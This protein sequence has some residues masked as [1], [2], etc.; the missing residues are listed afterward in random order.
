MKLPKEL[1]EKNKKK[2]L[3]HKI[4]RKIPIFGDKTNQFK[5]IPKE[6]L[7]NETIKWMKKYNPK[8]ILTWIEVISI[9][10][11]NQIYQ[12]RFEF[13]IAILVSIEPNNFQNN[14]LSYNVIK[15]FIQDFEKKSN[16]LF[17]EDYEPFSQLN[18][19]PYFFQTQ[20]YY[21]FYGLTGRIYEILKKI[22]HIYIFQDSPDYP[23]F[24]IFKSFFIQ[25]LDFQTQILKILKPLQES[26]IQTD[27]IYVPTLKF[28]KI[29]EPFLKI[30]PE[31]IADKRCILKFGRKIENT[32]N[33]HQKLFNGTYFKSVHI[34]VSKNEFYMILPQT[35]IETL[36]F[37]FK[38]I[39]IKSPNK[40][41]VEKY[42]D[43]NLLRNLTFTCGEFFTRKG[44]ILN[45][46][47]LKKDW[48]SQKIDTITLY[49][50]Y[51]FLFKIVDTFDDNKLGE[52]VNNAYDIL[53]D[54]TKK[55][56][57][58]DELL[59]DNGSGI[60]FKILINELT[61]FKFIVYETINLNVSLVGLKIEN[62]LENQLSSMMDITIMFE[63]LSSEL[64]FIKYIK[65]REKYLKNI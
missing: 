33:F 9:H 21:F 31:S 44:L 29:L 19:I 59:L 49:E 37:I 8:D 64:S 15:K 28:Y 52:E 40:S 10:P 13:L 54:V 46:Y 14:A 35:Q 6:H 12:I 38:E 42:I 56:A 23:E 34:Q 25:I 53:D 58:E 55:L 1:L 32:S 7:I 60:L 18:L 30:K 65:E 50:N 26:K 62:S 24:K 43:A 45:I 63:M 51:L 47:N 57:S 3:K 61:I 17:I 48:M 22:E 20:K 16:G 2:R 27:R 5:T 41:E 11:S 39:V 4:N 36:F